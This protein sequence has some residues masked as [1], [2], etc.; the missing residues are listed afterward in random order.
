[1][2]Y[3][4]SNEALIL[5]M[6]ECNEVFRFCA[7]KLRVLDSLAWNGSVAEEFFKNGENSLPKPSYN[8]DRQLLLDL[9]TQLDH[10]SGKLR[11]D[12]PV[13]QWLARTQESYRQGAQ[14][15]LGIETK[16][17][18]EISSQIYGLPKTKPF[19]NQIT[20]LDLADA[21]SNRMS[22]RPSDDKRDAPTQTAEEFAAALEKRLEGRRPR[23]PVRVELCD[24]LASRAAAG[25]SRVRIR[26]GTHFSTF[27]IISIFNHEIETHC[28]TAQNGNS[29]DNCGFLAFG[30]PRTTMTQEGLAIFF[31][32]YAH[33]LSQHRFMAL[34]DRVHA[35]KL[36]EDGASFIDLYRWYRERA[37]SPMEAFLLTQRVFRGSRLQGGYPLTKD[38]VYLSGLL[39]VYNFLRIAVKNQNRLLVESLVCGRVALEDLPAIAW[40]RSKGIIEAPKFTPWWLDNWGSLVSYFTFSSFLINFDLASFQVYFDDLDA[41]QKW[42]FTP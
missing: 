2:A 31:E 29:H 10:L 6:R 36:A 11:D 39:G 40:M 28:L 13:I 25:L 8:I 27:D 30:G 7:R 26:R 1:M 33:S 23:L 32:M 12:H 37:P 15:L 5:L 17:F 21:I 3:P 41:L 42:D 22:S 14:M 35:V 19:K 9:L 4:N 18:Y 34:C 38:V 20:N 24:D 16:S